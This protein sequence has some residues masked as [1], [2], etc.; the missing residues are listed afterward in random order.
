MQEFKNKIILGDCI[1]K[2]NTINEPF[3][4]LVFA[5]P[6][7]NI[8]FEYDKYDDN[9]D[10]G[11]YADWTF[12]WMQ[13]CN[14]ILKETGSFYVAIGDE[15][16]VDVKLAADR[17]NLF[18]RNWIIWHYSFGQQTKTKFARAHTHILY[19]VKNE[20]EFCFNAKETRIISDRQRNYRDKR[21]NKD[22]KMPDDV[23]DE[24]PRLCGTFEE[25]KGFHPCQMPESLL[26]RIIRVSSN[27]G[28]WV[29]DPF[30]GSGTTCVVAHK[31]KRN[32]TGI[33]LSPEYAKESRK[34]IKQS[35]SLP[36]IGENKPDWN[37]HLENELKWLYHENKVPTDQL[38]KD[39]YLLNIFTGKYNAR[40]HDG[41][42]IFT[43]KDISEKLLKLRKSAKLGPLKT[44]THPNEQ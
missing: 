4:D 27:Q 17:L 33:E 28:D 7:F 9:K 16:V 23:W 40:I 44:T 32:Y 34:R 30:S 6:P 14:K 11:D 1:T 15:H 36:V 31:L 2:L 39:T 21:A 8:G 37:S 42:N 22:G 10:A 12:R 13:A 3:V 24:Y 35:E 25:R 19:F 18:L 20:K 41:R 43:N 5:D 29:F 26:S 38:I